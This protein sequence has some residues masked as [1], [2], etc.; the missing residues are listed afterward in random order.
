MG[1]IRGRDSVKGGDEYCLFGKAIYDDEDGCKAG[2]VRKL[3][4]EIHGDGIPWFFRNGKLFEQSVWFVSWNLG[5][6]AGSAGFD[7]V[8]YIRV[9][10]GPC[11]F[12]TDEF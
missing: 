5:S 6:G 8:L 12:T 9:Y 7:V 1:E 4:Y 11:I 3:L 10:S 2:G